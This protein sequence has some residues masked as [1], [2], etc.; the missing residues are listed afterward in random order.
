M[1]SLNVIGRHM[2][3]PRGWSGVNEN[4]VVRSDWPVGRSERRE[5]E[6]YTPNQ[7]EKIVHRLLLLG[8]SRGGSGVLVPSGHGDGVGSCKTSIGIS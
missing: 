2:W 8:G 3:D 7:C 6:I 4:D 5:A 1:V